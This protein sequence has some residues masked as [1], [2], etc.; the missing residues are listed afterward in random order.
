MVNLKLLGN[1][2]QS[3]RKQKKFNQE[4][5]AYRVGISRNYL[6]LVETGMREIS[7][8]NLVAIADA[9]DT[10][11]TELLT[12]NQNMHDCRFVIEKMLMDCDAIERNLI[13]QI[14]K[15]SKEALIL[16]RTEKK[17]PKTTD[18]MFF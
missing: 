12:G 5:L 10:T 18:K 13:L 14:C 3:K 8:S 11:V 1:N 16:Y 15:S 4:E 7:L 17:K 6:S 9:L 2:I